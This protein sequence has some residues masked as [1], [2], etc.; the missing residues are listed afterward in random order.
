[1][2]GGSGDDGVVFQTPKRLPKIE[3]KAPPDRRMEDEGGV[4]KSPL[5]ELKEL[6]KEEHKAVVEG[7][8]G[9]SHGVQGQ[10]QGQGQA[11][12]QVQGQASGVQGS[13]VGGVG[14]VGGVEDSIK[15]VKPLPDIFGSEYRDL[16]ATI[17]REIVIEKPNVYFKDIVGCCT[18][19]KLIR[20][21]VV[22][23]IKYPE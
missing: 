17:Q 11:Q 23:P 3:S 1:M 16:A 12:T 14:G 18:A 20:E 22:Y 13:A 9:V 19:K 21:A 5:R 6:G 10:A 2:G 7:V 8:N 4:V 15:L